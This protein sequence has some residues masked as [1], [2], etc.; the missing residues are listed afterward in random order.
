MPCTT[1]TL[2]GHYSALL[3]MANWI[4]ALENRAISLIPECPNLF[5]HE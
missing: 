5:A 1:T 4:Q 2:A 3:I